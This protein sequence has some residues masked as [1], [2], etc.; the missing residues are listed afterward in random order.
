VNVELTHR[1]AQNLFGAWVD[2]ELGD[3]E[4]LG[5]RA[6]L[7]DCADCRTGWQRYERVVKGARNLEHIQAPPRLATLIARRV[8]RRRMGG[9]A[10]HL[11]HAHY[12]LPAE[13]IIPILLAAAV[14]ALLFFSAS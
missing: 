2:A 6:H 5:L 10:L 11:A 8:R 3:Q 13:V 12:R 1:E 7:D 14:A 9:R 4:E